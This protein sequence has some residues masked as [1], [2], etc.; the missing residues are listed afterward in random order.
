MKQIGIKVYRFSVSWPRVMPD[1]TGR[2]NEAGLQYYDRVIDTL[3]LQ[4]IE[5]WVT[6]YHWDLPSALQAK[7]GWLNRDTVDEFGAYA[8]VIAKRFDGR[9]KT[10]M[11]INEAQCVVG[12]GYG[13]GEHA[14][15]FAFQR[16]AGVMYAS[17]CAAHGVA[18]KRCVKQQLAVRIG[19]SPCGRLC[20]PLED[21][22]AAREAAYK[23]SFI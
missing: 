8:T 2:L 23:A 6:I 13:N 7:G 20:Y 16:G 17:P 12:L 4:G 21:S 5:P 10:Y 15:V 18:T 3:L 11:T 19:A 1:G 9:V 14:R 22:P